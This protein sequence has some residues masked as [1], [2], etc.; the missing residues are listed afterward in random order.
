VISFV[1]MVEMENELVG[2]ETGT[3]LSEGAH[4]Q[5]V[6]VIL[7]FYVFQASLQVRDLAIQK[8]ILSG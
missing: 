3:W 1:V 4:L 2:M 7:T 8:T 6:Y 5:M